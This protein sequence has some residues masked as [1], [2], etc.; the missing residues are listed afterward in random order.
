MKKTTE[1]LQKAIEWLEFSTPE[2]SYI[3]SRQSAFVQKLKQA[4]AELDVDEAEMR[5]RM[6]CLLR[7]LA[8]CHRDGPAN[9][10][11]HIRKAE[12]D[13]LATLALMEDL[14]PETE[15]HL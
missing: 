3:A 14:K 8:A 13:G 12:E 7:H 10:V 5:A 4:V 1:L 15:P 6:E 9:S 2:E 11:G